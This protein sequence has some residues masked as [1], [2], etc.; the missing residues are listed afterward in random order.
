MQ[1]IR[2]T[3]S[4]RK[5]RET[6]CLCARC[7]TR[8]TW[9][10]VLWLALL[11][12][13]TLCCQSLNAQ[14]PP[15][16]IFILADDV[17]IGDLG[18]YG[19]DAIRTPHIDQLADEGMRFTQMCSG[20]PVCSPSRAVLMTGLHNGRH[21]NGNGVS[22]HTGHVT[23][24]ELLRQRG[25]ATGAF[26]KWHLGNSGEALPT[27]QGFD[28]Y[29]GI[30]D[31]VAAWDHFNPTM[32]RLSDAAPDSVI[33]E[34]NDGQ[35]TDDL[36]GAEVADFFR[37]NAHA[38]RPFYAQVN[39][40]LAHFDME[41]PQLEPYTIGQ[42]WPDSRKIF[43]SMIS[44]LDR[45]VGDI[46]AA[47]DDPNGD[48]DPSDSIA[49][50][51]VIVF[52]S[53]N[54]THIEPQACCT[55]NHGPE[56]GVFS[57][58]PHDPEFF[59]SNGPYRGCVTGEVLNLGVVSPDGMS[60]TVPPTPQTPNPAL[61]FDFIG[62]QDD[63]PLS[64]TALLHPLLSLNAGLDFGPGTQPRSA[65]PN[66]NTATD[67]GDEFNIGGFDTTSLYDA[68]AAQDF[69][70]LTVQPK[71]GFQMRLLSVSYNLWRNGAN[72]A[73]DYAILTSIDG[74]VPGSEVAQ[75]NDVYVS[76]IDAQQMFTGFYPGGLAVTDPVEIRLYGWNANDNLASTHINAVSMDALFVLADGQIAGVSAVDASGTP[77]G[78]I[79]LEGNYV[80]HT[81]GVLEIDLGGHVAGQSYDQLRVTGTADVAD[82]LAI[83]LADGFEPLL[84]DDFELLHAEA[85]FN[86][87]FD[88][89]SLPTL[90]EPL[91]WRTHVM[92]N[93]VILSVVPTLPGDING[94]GYV[95]IGDLNVL[96]SHWNS[97]AL[98]TVSPAPTAG[99]VVSLGLAAGTIVCRTRNP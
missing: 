70:T 26:G 10:L 82:T 58:K 28:T 23:I 60:T 57:D 74:F 72:A 75:L 91:T 1:G 96:L 85:G 30:L 31:G 98:P 54:G 97:G 13:L 41:V 16:V 32:Q 33:Q 20:A 27:M 37:S 52:A 66:D 62:V 64:S 93:R 45:L 21:V 73:R 42:V 89:L 53:D 6:L 24:S 68:L 50:N 17:G 15:N 2:Y 99:I 76:G 95:G 87:L 35:F 79:V 81:G 59:D 92:S 46:V 18:S 83:R 5:A 63:A 65:A 67:D 44:R 12:C 4:A 84:G 55:A 7:P 43:A 47:V 36:V 71:T 56:L 48:G 38:G 90:P 80:Q 40:Q 78:L 61:A 39:F 25:Y 86:G 11:L 49:N 51:T 8:L 29:Y 22:L 88:H 14:T 77:Y 94:D 19:Q 34:I 9:R 69:L 3:H